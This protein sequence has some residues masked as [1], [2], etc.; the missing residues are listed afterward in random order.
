M[1]S[2]N[3]PPNPA[4]HVVGTPALPAPSDALKQLVSSVRGIG[5]VLGSAKAEALLSGFGS[6]A[7]MAAAEEEAL[8]SVVGAKGGEVRRFFAGE[9]A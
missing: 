9:L 5:G 2:G 8:R 7:G 6:L 3:G 1:A 4:T